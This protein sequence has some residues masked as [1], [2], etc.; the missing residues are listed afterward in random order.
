MESNHPS[1]WT[2]D[3]Q[4]VPL[5]LRYKLPLVEVKGIEPLLAGCRPAVQPTRPNPHI[6][7]DTGSRTQSACVT[8][9]H[10]DTLDHATIFWGAMPVSIRRCLIHS[11][12]NCHCSNGSI[13]VPS[14]GF[15]PWTHGLR[16]RCSCQT[17]L[18]GHIGGDTRKLNRDIWLNRP[19][20][21]L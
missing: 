8:G 13:L 12:A 3:L 11:Q 2:T 16:D 9:K 15:E 4:S 14:Q 10:H 17:E 6:G 18:R 5:P 7:G 20:F 1:R 21:Y 19:P